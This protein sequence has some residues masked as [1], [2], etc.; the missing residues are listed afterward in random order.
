ME[1]QAH[2]VF[3]RQ[4]ARCVRRCNLAIA[5]SDDRIRDDAPGTEERDEPGLQPVVGDLGKLR[6]RQSRDA[7]RIGE[8]AGERPLRDRFK[9]RVAL[10]ES[11]L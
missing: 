9:D 8:R 2:A 4:R 3:Q 11:P 7:D 10:L 6:F 5:V 1:G